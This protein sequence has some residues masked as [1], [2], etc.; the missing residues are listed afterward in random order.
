MRSVNRF[1]EYAATTV[2][3]MTVMRVRRTA[4]K[5][6]IKAARRAGC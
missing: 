4:T 1:E 6:L 2:A 5:M 3:V